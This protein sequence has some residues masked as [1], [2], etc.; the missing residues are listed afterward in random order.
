MGIRKKIKRIYN[1]RLI[2]K[3]YGKFKT[4]I[5]I[6]KNWDKINLNRIALINLAISNILKKNKT[7]NYLE[8]GCD[9]NFVFNSIILPMKFKVGIDPKKGGNFK[10]KSDNFFKINKKKFDVIFV[11][12][13]HHYKQCQRDVINSLNCLNKNGYLFIHDLLPLD[14]RMELVPRIQGRWNGDV[15]K[16][17]FELFK[18]K[19]LKFN[20]ADMDSGVGFLKKTSNKF[21]YNKID[22]LKD[23]RF[24]DYLKIYKQLPVI[25]AEKALRLISKG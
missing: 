5:T 12:G 24:L 15:W 11:D 17:G 10:I 2:D 7:C 22:E 6:K 23:L 13:L 20:I 19:N 25:E 3:K 18:S 4:E 16:V 21:V 14:W 9:D 8:V 1:E